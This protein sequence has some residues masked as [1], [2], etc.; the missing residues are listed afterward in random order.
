MA[1]ENLNR[2]NIRQ[3]LITRM[4]STLG[5]DKIRE[6]LANVTV[7]SRQLLKRVRMKTEQFLAHKKNEDN[8]P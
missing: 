5:D 8:L 2:T 1:A 4:S 7:L 3:R 6:L